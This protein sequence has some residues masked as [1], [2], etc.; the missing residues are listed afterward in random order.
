MTRLPILL[1]LLAAV[2][3]GHGVSGYRTT[4]AA[5]GELLLHYDDGFEIRS[6]H[7]KV[8]AGPGF[9]GLTDYVRCVPEARRHAESAEAYGVGATVMSGFS[10]GVAAVGLGSLAGLSLREKDPSTMTALLIGGVVLEAI[11][12]G[13]GAGSLGAKSYANGNALDAVNYYNDAVGAQGGSCATVPQTAAA[14][15]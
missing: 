9:G 3:C 13:L 7:G 12:I 5:P 10:I 8:T 2:G 15:P 6:P 14:G 1:C 11:A 4:R